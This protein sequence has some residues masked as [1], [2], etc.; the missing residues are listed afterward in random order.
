MDWPVHDESR[1]ALA[2]LLSERG[3][4]PAALAVLLDGVAI[5]PARFAL[6]AAR[7]QA[8][9]G[10]PAG[11]LETAARVPP[12][13]RDAE[14]HALVA[15]LAQ[16][17]GRHE[18]AIAEYRAALAPAGTRPRVVWWIGLGVS[19][20]KTGHLVDAFEAYGHVHAQDGATAAALQFAAQRLAALAGFVAEAAALP[21]ALPAA[22]SP[23]LPVRP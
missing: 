7:L 2:T 12:A 20:E 22:P 18:L 15:A 8:E 23:S 14:Y 19:L 16:R 9:L 6:T 13:Q 4:R 17:T 10:N 1:N 5:A 11:A 3:Q 21:A